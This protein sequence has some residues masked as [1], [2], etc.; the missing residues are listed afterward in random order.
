LYFLWAVNEGRIFVCNCS[1]DAMRTLCGAPMGELP[2]PV[3]EKKIENRI[4]IIYNL[5]YLQFIIFRV[6]IIFIYMRTTISVVGGVLGEFEVL[7]LKTCSLY[8]DNLLLQKFN[9][10]IA[11]V[12]KQFIFRFWP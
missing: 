4:D 6:Y 2:A 8:H 12:L 1:S 3:S 9:D 11:Q 5:Y 10:M 7:K